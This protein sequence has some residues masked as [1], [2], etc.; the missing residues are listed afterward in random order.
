MRFEIVEGRKTRSW[1]VAVAKGDL[2]VEHGAG[3]AH[4]VV[5]ADRGVFEKLATGRMNAFAAV[6]RGELT[7][8]G[9][10][11]LLVSMQRLFPGP[12]RAKARA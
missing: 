8:D 7:V 12:R 6:L 10:W 1:C 3:E 11:R 5:R 9:D 4:C 2:T